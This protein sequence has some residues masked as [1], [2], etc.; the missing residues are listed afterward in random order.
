MSERCLECSSLMHADADYHDVPVCPYCDSSKTRLERFER[1]ARGAL[2]EVKQTNPPSAADLKARLQG[3]LQ[4]KELNVPAASARLFDLIAREKTLQAY[5]L[6]NWDL[7]KWFLEDIA[8]PL[9]TVKDEEIE[10]FLE[11]TG[12]HLEDLLALNI[13]ER[14]QLNAAASLL[15]FDTR[16][17]SEDMLKAAENRRTLFVKML[18]TWAEGVDMQSKSRYRRVL[19]ILGEYDERRRNQFF[20]YVRKEDR[21]F[22][23]I[24][25]KDRLAHLPT[26]N[27]PPSP[28]A[29]INPATPYISEPK[30]LWDIQTAPP[31]K[32]DAFSGNHVSA[33]SPPDR[34]VV[35]FVTPRRVHLMYLALV[36]LLLLGN[37]GLTLDYSLVLKPASDTTLQHA[38]AV[39]TGI[40]GRIYPTVTTLAG[41]D[42]SLQATVTADAQNAQATQSALTQGTPDAHFVAQSA[43]PPVIPG[44]TLA[45]YFDLRNTGTSIWSAAQSYQLN[46]T[47]AKHATNSAYTP[48]CLGASSVSLRDDLVRPGDE[49]VFFVVIRI[50]TTASSGTTYRTYWQLQ[51]NNRPVGNE[52]G[53][54]ELKVQKAS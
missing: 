53:Y 24:L 52:E 32:P 41:E 28:I 23:E 48:D 20:A 27:Y 5:V 4:D 37:A 35:K 17:L 7:L 39:S 40:A 30:A 8:N 13:A 34:T 16:G 50:P 31:S 14:W 38:Y 29:E 54:I 1:A 33:G 26:L 47:S 15:R 10:P 43:A 36:I 25:E 21:R 12:N 9:P 19:H 45:L 2:Q 51:Q 3:F 42:N 11:V 44:Q 22:A 18:R 6:A 49:Y 46:C